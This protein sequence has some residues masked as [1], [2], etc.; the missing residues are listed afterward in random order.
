MA[1]TAETLRVQA[2]IDADLS[3]VVDQQTRDLTRAWIRAWDETADELEAAVQELYRKF[4]SGEIV[5]KTLVARNTRLLNA[6]DY[7]G[8]QLETLARDAGVRILGDLHPVVVDAARA[9]STVLGT[10]LP[11]TYDL[12]GTVPGGAIDAIVARSAQQITSRTYDLAPAAYETMRRE[13]ITGVVIG[14]NPNVTAKKMVRRTESRFNGGLA[15]AIN[16]SRTETIDAHRAAA[17]LGQS[18]HTDVL[19]GWIWLAHLSPRTCPSCIAMNGTLHPLDEPGPLDH[20]QGRCARLPKTRSW[21]DLGIRLPEPAGVQVPNSREWFSGLSSGEQRS[22][23]GEAG[24]DAWRR[25]TFPMEN[26]AERRTSTAWRDSLVPA[27]PPREA[28]A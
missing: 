4:E 28:A 5:S 10:Q 27:R 9:Q 3:H 23:L 15:R 25:G 21:E 6:L 16:I 19:V 11:P 24:Y 18:A 14:A 8:R 1:L 13:L 17:A 22:I 7:M 12:T 26:W 2:R 20:Q